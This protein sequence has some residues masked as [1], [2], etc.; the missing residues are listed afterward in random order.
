MESGLSLLEKWYRQRCNGDWEH[1]GRVKIDTLDNPDWTI[2][3]SLDETKA[4]GRT[5]Q[6]VKIERTEDD[7][8][9]YWVEKKAFHARCGPLN[10]SE[11]ISI[12]VDW[13]ES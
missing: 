3:I 10:L 9:H 11:T 5:I 13:F 2:T 6:R 12:F 8:I 7:W 1:Q 4:E